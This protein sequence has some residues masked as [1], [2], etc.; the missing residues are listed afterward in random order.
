M[1]VFKLTIILK[2]TSKKHIKVK[3][4]LKKNRLPSLAVHSI[5]LYVLEATYSAKVLFGDIFEFSY[6]VIEYFHHIHFRFT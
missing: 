4:M 3:S 6:N 1:N 2:T 5:I